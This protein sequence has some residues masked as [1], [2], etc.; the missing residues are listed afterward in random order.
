MT[1]TTRVVHLLLFLIVLYSLDYWLTGNLSISSGDSAIWLHSGLLMIVLGLYWIEPFFTKPSD[2]VVNALVVFVSVSTLNAPPYQYW[3]DLIRYGSLVMMV[4][5][6][7]SVLFGVP[8]NRLSNSPILVRFAYLVTTKLG[9]AKVI[10]SIVFFLSI[11]SYFDLED[12][13]TKWFVFAWLVIVLAKE[14]ELGNFLERL[15]SRKTQSATTTIGEVTRI[16]EPNI[17]RFSMP[18]GICEPGDVVGFSTKG[19]EI[20]NTPLACVLNHRTTAN[21]LEVESLLIDEKYFK[22][23]LASGCD[24]FIVDTNENIFKSRLDDSQIYSRR[25]ANI[26]YALPG[27]DINRVLFETI[28]AIDLEEGHLV[29]VSTRNLIIFYQ[30]THAKL[31]SEVTL[32]GSERTY[33]EVSAEQLGQWNHDRQGFVAYGWS[34]SENTPVFGIRGGVQVPENLHPDTTIGMVPNTEYPVQLNIESFVLYHSAILGVTGAGKSYLAFD[35]IEK[36]AATGIKVICLDVTGDYKRYLNDCVLLSNGRQVKPFL[37]STEGPNIGIIEFSEATHPIEATNIVANITKTWCQ[38]NRRDED[39]ISPTPKALLV[40]EEAHT[41]IP[42]WNFNPVRNLQDKV[43]S[44]AQI[45]LQA[46]KYGLGFCVITQRTASV[47][48]SIL[49]QC[50]SILSFQAFDETGFEFMKNYMGTRYVSALPGLKQR[51][52]VLVGKA[53]KS[54]KPLIVKFNDQ[55]RTVRTD[56]T[57][58]WSDE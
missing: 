16:S 49:N 56:A 43:S 42:E 31:K 58:T 13:R 1:K 28:A 40:L 8:G 19:G 33:T 21:R 45:V 39:F 37:E 2:V 22:T 46:R 24:V 55:T 41:L 17:V 5:A 27:S 23:A 52:G 44:T 18:E 34:P 36:C 50:N 10:F 48:K 25:T 12:H 30:I 57:P 51:Q 53:S 11:I 26:G 15:L 32:D 35:I 38:E 4:V 6:F 9:N 7:A 3:W 54:S 47:T 14:F 29:C 20:R